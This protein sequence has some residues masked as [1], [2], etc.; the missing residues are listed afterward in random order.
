MTWLLIDT[1]IR[2]AAAGIVL[3][4]GWTIWRDGRHR[5]AARL[6]GLLCLTV[7]AHL[8]TVAPAMPKGINLWEFPFE[9]ASISVPPLFW[10]V[11]LAV[12]VDDYRLRPLHLAIA[13][14]YVLYAALFIVDFYY[15][16]TV[17]V[18]AA[19]L[20]RSAMFGFVIAALVVAWRGRAD[21]L[22]EDRRRLRDLLIWSIGILALAIPAMEVFLFAGL[23]PVWSLTV[24]AATVL[25][26]T[27]VNAWFLVGL[28]DD[29]LLRRAAAVVAV[30]P[31][32]A[33][34]DEPRMLGELARL[35]DAERL[36]R[37][38]T[39]GIGEL[40]QRIGVPEYRL[41]RLINQ[42]LGHRNF[43]AY[44]NG[45]RLAEVR[46]AL[47]DPAQRDVPILTMALDAGFGSLAPFN[48]A[49]RD[50]EGMTPSEY[51]ERARNGKK[52]PIG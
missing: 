3:I 48:R 29:D 42:R 28:R 24:S 23:L 30:A 15:S 9:I 35:M 7:I 1:A 19:T 16:D 39:L 5:L 6:T 2:S 51:R 31:P 33:D 38:D 46:A 18:P 4:L 41:R 52:P 10:L 27:L 20:L 47:A 25:A 40:A 34:P 21:D 45:Y 36:Y 11:A 26:I 13:G 32:P 43:A 50:S 49:F 22:V 17:R 44:L 8:V 37:D 12:F 14:A